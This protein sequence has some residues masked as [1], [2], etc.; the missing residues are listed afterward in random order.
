MRMQVSFDVLQWVH[1]G[2]SLE[3]RGSPR[4]L[5]SNSVTKN[6][7]AAED[8][9][10]ILDGERI[11][12]SSTVLSSC[13]NFPSS[14][15]PRFVCFVQ[16]VMA[17]KN[18]TGAGGIADAETARLIALKRTYLNLLPPP[19]IID[20]CLTF[21]AYVPIHVKHT[22]WPLDLNAA[23]A[24]L[25]SQSS[26][27][28]PPREEPFERPLRDDQ[29]PPMG[30]LVDQSQPASSNVASA[31]PADESGARPTSTSD[32]PPQAPVSMHAPAPLVA[33]VKH[34]PPPQPPYP[35]QPYGFVQTAYPH[36][37]YYPPPPPG[38]PHYPHAPVPY[39]YPPHGMHPQ[40]PHHPHP[41]PQP[42][43]TTQQLS[44]QHAQRSSVPPPHQQPHAS[45]SSAPVQPHVH[46]PQPPIQPQPSDPSQQTPIE[47]LP[48]YEEMIVEALMDFQDP[49]GS[50]PKNLFTWMAERYPLQTNFRP[51]ASQALQ[52]AFKRG[53]LEKSD[54]G[55]YRLNAAWEGGS[56]SRRTT[57]RPQ[58]VTQTGGPSHGGQGPLPPSPFT[59]APLVHTRQNGTPAAAEVPK[60]P[61]PPPPVSAEPARATP[62]RPHDPAFPYGYPTGYQAKQSA[63]TTDPLTDAGTE[64]AANDEDTGVGS[65]AWEAAQNILK[66]INFGSLL[67]ISQD[68]QRP[69]PTGPSDTTAPDPRTGLPPPMIAGAGFD[70]STASSSTAGTT[71][72]TSGRGELTGDERAALQAQLALLAAQ[73]AEI[74]QED[75]TGLDLSNIP[76]PELGGNLGNDDDQSEEGE[77]EDDED[78][79][80]D[81]EAVEVPMNYESVR[82]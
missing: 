31:K 54:G 55:K 28:T 2:E 70:L 37:P 1:D 57:R 27:H 20:L 75:V 67:Q 26:S 79:D 49:E 63:T 72:A 17:L 77:E 80:A 5:N 33:P 66:A 14:L 64:S 62:N 43:P 46:P 6:C 78:E 16:N 13:S 68:E 82:T 22:T 50:A 18:L 30:A 53:R 21:D 35:H 74:A 19:Q 73:L 48:S 9:V 47:D 69:P 11:S 15:S 3:A 7:A 42:P 25:Q 60:P 61:P 29:P 10:K 24:A 71:T 44:Y 58:T 76:G 52:K 51:S 39:P 41:H 32:P 23:I 34:Q 36:S 40:P 81:M 8:G 4:S 56:T 38:Y 12:T 65:D 59:R 45:S